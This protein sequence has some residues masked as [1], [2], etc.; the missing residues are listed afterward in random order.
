MGVWVRYRLGVDAIWTGLGLPSEETGLEDRLG[1]LPHHLR[2]DTDIDPQA[3][4]ADDSDDREKKGKGKE[5]KAKGR[6]TP[7]TPTPSKRG[8]RV[9]KDLRRASR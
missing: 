7:P 5:K 3:T 2:T 8:G 1:L 4:A 9:A 6:E